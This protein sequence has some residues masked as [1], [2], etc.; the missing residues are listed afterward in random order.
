MTGESDTLLACKKLLDWVD[1]AVVTEG[2]SGLTLCGYSE[3][4]VKR[5]TR[6]PVR[7]KSIERYNQ[8]E[9]SRMVRRQ[10][11]AT[12][13]QVFSHT[14]PY[15]GGPEELGSTSGAGDA[16]LAAVLHDVAANHY[17]RATMPESLKHA[18]PI[19][20][21]TYSSI[22]R[23]AQYA[24]RVAY[25]VLKQRSPRLEGAVGSDDD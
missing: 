15:R 17:H 16:A 10:D 21:L 4:S 5:E 9:F 14:H 3:D 23:N 13:I 11:C 20:F 19:P 25:E 8:F 6:L 2:A 22:A 12:P 1:V 18:S 7:S 24:N